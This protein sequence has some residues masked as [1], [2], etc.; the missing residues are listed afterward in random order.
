[1]KRF[2]NILVICDDE[3]GLDG[4][5]AR[6]RWLAKANDA[7]ITLMDCVEAEPG[8]LARLFSALP[9]AQGYELEDQVFP[10]HRGRLDRLAD[11][12]RAEGLRVRT[13]V[14][15]GVLFLQAIRQVMRDDH[16]LVV[17]V[18]QRGAGRPLFSGTDMH[19]MRKCPCAVW[20]LKTEGEPRARRILAAIDPDPQDAVRH[21]LCQTVLELAT[22]LARHDDAELDVINVWRVQEE[23][24]LRHS[25]I[26][27]PETDVTA[28]LQQEE[29][30]SAWRL[31]SVMEAFPDDH[32][33]RRVLHVK[34]VAGEVIPDHARTEAIDTI[35]MGTLGRTGVAGFFIGN[36]AETILSRADCAVLAVKPPG[37]VSPVEV[38]ADTATA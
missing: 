25:L 29:R 14:S 27:M 13:M 6:M 24:T 30:R 3:T 33:R 20:I 8:A 32:G 37:F 18:A 34:G 12:L 22:S 21:Q 28:I 5:F 38:G 31:N 10:F 7:S 1:M 16:D 15:Q 26:K 36:T 19:L 4:A 2:R 23:S 35:V 11:A 9:G 17:K